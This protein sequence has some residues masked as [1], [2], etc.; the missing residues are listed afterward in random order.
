MF[1]GE[2]MNFAK[3]AV[4]GIVAASLVSP[5]VA[6]AS[7]PIRPA[8]KAAISVKQERGLSVR[9]PARA[10]AS[11]ESAN[12]LIGLPLLA[13]IASVAAATVAVAVAVDALDDSGS[14]GS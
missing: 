1:K 12:G 4:A 7:N 5:A 10:G 13:I 3:L 6:A 14:P 11:V 8:A 9:R 2:F